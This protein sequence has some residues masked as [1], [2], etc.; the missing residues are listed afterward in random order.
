MPRVA[1]RAEAHWYTFNFIDYSFWFTTDWNMSNN[2]SNTEHS[3][4]DILL[5]IS[6]LNSNIFICSITYDD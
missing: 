5:A 6:S 4:F 2:K 1:Y 3:A